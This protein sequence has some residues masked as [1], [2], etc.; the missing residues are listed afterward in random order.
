VV[1]KQQ[2]SIAILFFSAFLSL[3]LLSCAQPEGASE[4]TEA[5]DPDLFGWR[6]ASWSPFTTLDSVKGFAYGGGVYVAVGRNGVIAWSNDGIRWERA[7]KKPDPASPFDPTVDP[8]TY[9]GSNAAHFNAAA[10]G[11]GVFVAVAENGHIAYSSDGK[12]WAGVHTIGGFG[13]ENVNGVAYGS[14]YFVAVG[15]NGNISAAF[16]SKPK[17]WRGGTVFTGSPNPA[18]YDIT[19]GNG[20][21]YVVGEGG[22]T[23]YAAPGAGT[24]TAWGGGWHPRQ[25]ASIGTNPIRKI[26]CGEYGRGVP[27][28]GIAFDEYGGKR[29][30]LCAGGKI[31]YSK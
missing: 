15:G 27:G 1:K 13:T 23:G 7:Q 17:I 3:V 31:G 22:W 9:D 4:E 28:L 11:G 19:F 10:F 20:A 21:F 12:Y 29:I 16:P 26:T 2:R 24:V 25:W 14:G 8:F 5:W 18:L 30:A 6:T